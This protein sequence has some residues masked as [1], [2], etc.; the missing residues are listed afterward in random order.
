M[1]ESGSVI[2]ALLLTAAVTALAAG[3]AAF[4]PVTEVPII[5]H[6]QIAPQDQALVHIDF[7]TEKRDTPVEGVDILSSILRYEL[8]VYD[9][10]GIRD[11]LLSGEPLAVHIAVQGCPAVLEGSLHGTGSFTGT[12][13]GDGRAHLT[14]RGDVLRGYFETGGVA[15][16]VESTGRYDTESPGKVLHYLFSSADVKGLS[17]CYL[18]LYNISNGDLEDS[19]YPAGWTEADFLSAGHEVVPLTDA[20]LAR[21]PRVN[22]T[23]R[24]GFMEVPLSE[25]ETMRIM[26]GYRGRIAE[27]RG[28]YYVIDFIES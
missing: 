18:T 15:Y 5:S 17:G 19:G 14:I 27:Y 20:D 24:T 26:N 22:E 12:L 8:A 16:W 6:E 10:E 7:F 2:P 13:S 11:H 23:L 4:A 28:N 1:T 25:S 9:T 3:F 21:L